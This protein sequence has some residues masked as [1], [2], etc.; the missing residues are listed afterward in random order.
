MPQPVS[1]ATE[2]A[3]RAA[4]RRLLE[5]VSECTDGRL[6]I[7]NLAREAGVS[8]ATANRAAAILDEFRTAE[9]QFRSG[10]AAGLKARIRELEAELRLARGREM[11][12]LRT[13]IRTLAQKIQALTLHSDDQARLISTMKEQLARAEP[14]IL[15]FRPLP[16]GSS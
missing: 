12:E 2:E 16:G 15:P 3:L 10:S 11:T 13:M 6:T 7:A 1:Q 5:G 9:A 14:N 8:R 4:M